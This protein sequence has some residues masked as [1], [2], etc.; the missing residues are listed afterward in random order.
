VSVQPDLTRKVRQ[1]DND[2]YALYEL[3]LGISIT[4]TRHGNRLDELAATQDT[5]TA[6]LAGHT[7]TLAGHTATLAEHTATLA[8]HGGKLDKI[9]ELLERR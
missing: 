7:A 5:H 4:Q 9:I 3:V 6:T 2:V 1:L 8:E